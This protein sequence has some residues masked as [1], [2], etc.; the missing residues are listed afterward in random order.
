M[1]DTVFVLGAGAS[2]AAGAPLMAN[3]LDTAHE[4]WKTGKVQDV[5]SDFARVFGAVSAL[6][7]VHSKATLDINNV[8]SVF[9][10]LEMA[11]MLRKFPAPPSVDVDVDAMV[12]SLK[13]VIGTTLERTI[14]IPWRQGRPQPP[15][16][17]GQF[18]KLIRHLLADADPRRTVS[19]I[20]FNYDLACDFGLH[21]AH[22]RRLR[23]E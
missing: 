6:Q 23:T 20:T 15:H 22:F 21:C 12:E 9:A 3:F 19:I 18:A 1:S 10:T 13:L 8:E 4:L 16:P 17:Y 7:A 2:K 5:E 11:A 14:E